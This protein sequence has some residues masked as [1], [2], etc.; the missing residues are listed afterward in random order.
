MASCKDDDPIDTLPEPPPD[1]PVPDSGPDIGPDLRCTVPKQCETAGCCVIQDTPGCGKAAI[2]ECVCALPEGEI[3]CNTAWDI[4]C[5][6]DVGNN[7]GGECGCCTP[8]SE[9][10]C[11]DAVMGGAISDCVCAVDP[12]CCVRQPAGPGWDERCVL[13]V[14][15]CA[16][17]TCP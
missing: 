15:D 9:G 17:G 12:A 10:G 14:N 13:E 7:C 1:A 11:Y 6:E 8:H 3:C 2:E 16:S 4:V 5:V